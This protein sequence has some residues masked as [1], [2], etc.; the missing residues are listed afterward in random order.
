MRQMLL[1]FQKFITCYCSYMDV[2]HRNQFRF[3]KKDFH[4]SKL[5]VFQTFPA[6]IRYFYGVDAI[7]NYLRLHF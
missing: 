2:E 5:M 4:L 3:S 7:N 6:I 1:L